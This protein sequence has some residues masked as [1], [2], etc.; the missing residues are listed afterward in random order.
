MEKALQEAFDEI[1]DMLDGKL[2]PARCYHSLERLLEQSISK[3]A[4]GCTADFTNTASRLHRACR[5]TGHPALPLEVF[6]ARAWQIRQHRQLPDATAFACDLKAVCE[7]MAAFWGI[8]L[9]QDI[10]RRLPRHWK[11]LPVPDGGSR[12]RRMRITVH[13]WDDRF[14]YGHENDHPA[15]RLLKIRY[16]GTADL[17]FARLAEQLYEGA[18][19]NLTDISRET[20]STEKGCPVLR[21]E[22][23]VLDPDFLIDITAVCACMQPCGW[24]AYAHLLAKFRPA[25]QTAA[26]ML[27]NAANQFL[28]DCVNERTAGAELENEDELYLHSIQESFRRHPLAYSTLPDID[29]HFFD[30]CRKQ[31]SHIRQTIEGGFTTAGIDIRNTEVQLEPSFLCEALGLQGR[32]DLLTLDA[33]KLVEL[34]SGKA[35]EYPARTPKEEHMLQMALYKEVLYHNMNLPREQVQSYLFY[36]RYPQLY[37]ADVPREKIR[38]AIALRNEIVHIERRLAE[39]ESEAVLRELT[40]ERIN[41]A[42]RNDRFYLQYLRPGILETLAPLKRMDGPEKTYFHRFLTFMEKE[43]FLAKVGNGR[44][45]STGGFA[46]AWCHDTQTKQQDGNILTGLHLTP[47][48]SADGAVTHVLLDFPDY[49]DDFLPNFRQGDMVMLYEKNSEQDSVTGRQFFRCTVEEIHPD[50]I[51]LK[52]SFRQRN[53]GVFPAGSSYAVEPGYTDTPFRQA[54]AGL[55][56]FL[57]AP[58]ERKA[59]LLGT[60]APG[61][62]SSRTLNRHYL[63]AEIDDIVL[64]AKQAEDYFLLE[65]PPGTGKTSVALRSMVEEFLSEP[66]EKHLLL[67]AYTNRA[68]DEICAMLGTLSP[69]PDYIRIGQEPGCAPAFRPRLLKNV[70]GRARTRRQIYETLMPVRLFVGTVNSLCAQ[71]ELLKMKVFDVAIIDEASQVLEPQLLPLLCHSREHRRNDIATQECTIRKF[72]LIGDHKQLPAVV[73]QRPQQSCVTEKTLNA[74]GLTDCR[75]SL[76]ERLHVLNATCGKKNITAMLHK[77]GRMHPDIARF[78]SLNFYGGKL[79]AVPLPHQLEEHPFA[80]TPDGGAWTQAV[81]RTRMGLLHVAGNRTGGNPKSNPQE[82]ETVA[83][84]VNTLHTL[85]RLNHS[86]GC[87][88]AHVGIIVPFRAQIAMVRRKLEELAP[89]LPEAAGITIDTV[90]RYQG[91]QRDVIIFSTTVSRDW[92]LDT[93][94]EPVMTGSRAVDRKLNVA[95]TRA[96]KQFFLVGDAT[97]LQRCEAYRELMACLQPLPLPPANEA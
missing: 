81:A 34:K 54:Y 5:Q 41:T 67:M 18:Q 22:M 86:E 60:R 92:Q 49:G 74:I 94:S 55:F 10:S 26:I 91:S 62:D 33:G 70:I 61:T 29:R 42:G 36:S 40:E 68:V 83:R 64:K 28:D 56:L 79:D 45:D 20:G 43:Q 14:V 51:L 71:T 35:D 48:K 3:A 95:L 32:M 88:A 31:F 66:S 47:Q 85:F 73:M 12:T 6:R 78:A 19:L 90:E 15:G 4:H 9:P 38:R 46:A 53:A 69:I 72:I 8:P 96:R 39:G 87:I 24:S 2:P 82:A 16:N 17:V 63:N 77:Q 13:R 84:L 76:F 97:L 50:R 1:R 44:P 37:A 59:L 58:P 80:Q 52:L 27:G 93:L 30:Q 11:P 25:A 21:P 7:G 89:H 23:I 57:T 65:G 75:N